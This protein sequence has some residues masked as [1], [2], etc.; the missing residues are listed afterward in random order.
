MLVAEINLDYS[1]EGQPTAK[2]SI[3]EVG[4]EF[5]DFLVAVA[6]DIP[7]FAKRLGDDG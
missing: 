2:G 3:S 5:A 4:P 7:M 6:K 1:G